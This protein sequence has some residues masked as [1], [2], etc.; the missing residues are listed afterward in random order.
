MRLLLAGILAL[1]PVSVWADTPSTSTTDAFDPQTMADPADPNK[2]G[3]ADGQ[4]GAIDTFS[5]DQLW[6]YGN[7]YSPSS[8]T[9]FQALIAAPAYRH[10]QLSPHSY[11]PEWLNDPFGRYGSLSSPDLMNRRYNVDNPYSPDS[12][13]HSYNRGGQPERR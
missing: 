13:M 3:N 2:A 4:D 1:L 11:E 5:L 12:P 8:A 7:P 9:N 10:G 6:P